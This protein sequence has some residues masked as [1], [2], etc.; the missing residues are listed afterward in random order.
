MIDNVAELV[1]ACENEKLHIAVPDK[2][3]GEARLTLKVDRRRR[4]KESTPAVS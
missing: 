3:S 4:L 1:L 2:R